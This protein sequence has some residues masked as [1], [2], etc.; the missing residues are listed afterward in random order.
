M[1]LRRTTRC[2]FAAALAVLAACQIGVTRAAEFLYDNGVIFSGT[3]NAILRI[4]DTAPSPVVAY[5]PVTVDQDG[6]IISVYVKVTLSSVSG[7]AELLAGADLGAMPEAKQFTVN[8]YLATRT[9]GGAYGEFQLRKSEPLVIITVD[10]ARPMAEYYHAGLNHYFLTADSAEQHALDTGV[11]TG[12]IRTGIEFMSYMAA[13][14][15][16][17]L[18]PVCRY[19]GL[20]SAGLNT[21]FYSVNPAE[22]AYVAQAWP[23]KWIEESPRAFDVLHLSPESGSCPTN[24][25]PVIRFYNGKY[26]VNHRYVATQ[27]AEQEMTAKGWIREGRVWCTRV[28]H[29]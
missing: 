27:S 19:Y 28:L 8:Y 13:G 11:F 26:D 1:H 22:C 5:E 7:P 6:S 16:P 12:W 24:T 17:P 20:P 2:A 23:D 14:P 9:T 10:E 3:T 15:N 25:F 29:R 21:H 4:H 18:A